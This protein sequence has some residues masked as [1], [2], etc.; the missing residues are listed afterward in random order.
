MA[1]YRTSFA[2]ATGR[3]DAPVAGLRARI[4]SIALSLYLPIGCRA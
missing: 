3:F 2:I 1:D 4:S